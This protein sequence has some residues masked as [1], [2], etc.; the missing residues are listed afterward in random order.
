VLL[1]IGGPGGGTLYVTPFLDQS[2]SMTRSGA[3]YYFSQDGLGSVSAVTDGSGDVVGRHDYAAFG[4]SRGVGTV[5]QRYGYAG[6][7]QAGLG[8]LLFNRYRFQEPQIG[9]VTS[10]DPLYILYEHPYSY[11]RG[12]PVRWTDPMG[13]VTD[14]VSASTAVS[15][16]KLAEA[17]ALAAAAKAALDPRMMT[18][19]ASALKVA[20]EALSAA[21]WARGVSEDPADVT[22]ARQLAEELNAAAAAA[23]AAYARAT[24]YVEKR[25]DCPQDPCDKA[26][27][28]LQHMK[29]EVKGREKVIKEHQRCITDPAAHMVKELPT[30]ENIARAVADW[31]KHIN[32]HEA[33]IAALK[34]GIV[35]AQSAI[36]LACGGK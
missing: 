9:R 15:M 22:R 16:T 1:D 6:R 20:A 28:V 17:F 12:N 34:A 18:N 29:D 13:L 36:D 32:I 23:S 8:V 4:V 24:A 19:A 21:L 33:A 11:A 35:L 26:K 14:S 31:T 27:R 7:E 2:L 10:R 30:P 3:V 5:L 25:E